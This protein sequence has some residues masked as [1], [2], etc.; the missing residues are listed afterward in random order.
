MIEAHSNN[1]DK[2][3]NEKHISQWR[4]SCRALEY[5]DMRVS[6]SIYSP[7]VICSSTVY[8]VYDAG[9]RN[10]IDGIDD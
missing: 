4:T 2:N 9:I 5:S 3:M 1:I 8:F 7:N 10:N 6:L